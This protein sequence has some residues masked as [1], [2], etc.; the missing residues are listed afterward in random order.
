MRACYTV[1]K[2]PSRNLG[3]VASIWSAGGIALFVEAAETGPV[4]AD[5]TT[6]SLRA[7]RPRGPSAIRHP[8]CR[9]PDQSPWA[10]PPKSASP[11]IES[12]DTL[13][14]RVTVRSLS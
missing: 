11:F 12:P 13:P 3:R 5:A 10:K 7:R 4:A 8:L 6:Y 1:T 9:T 14:V 2:R